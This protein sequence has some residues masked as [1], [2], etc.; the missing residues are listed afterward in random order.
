[1]MSI[2]E[3][4]WALRA[5]KGWSQRYLAAMAGVGP[6]CIMRLEDGRTKY[7]MAESL[8]AIANALEVTVEELMQGEE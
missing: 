7:P 8:Q 4:V 2:G 1:M 6:P 3:R 5:A